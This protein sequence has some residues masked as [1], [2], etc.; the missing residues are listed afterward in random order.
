MHA[1]LDYQTAGLE[2]ILVDCWSLLETGAKKSKAPFHTP[3]L[4]TAQADGCSLRTVVLRRV[5]ASQRLLI[6]HTDRRSAK[7]AE[8]GKHNSLSWLFYDPKKKIQ[9]RARGL[10]TLHFDDDLADE[11]WSRTRRM[12]R[13]CYCVWEAPGTVQPSRSS[14]LPSEYEGGSPTWEQSEQGRE[15]FAVIRCQVDFLDWLYLDA[16]G[17]SRA[18]FHWCGEKF[19]ARWVTP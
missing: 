1:T 8:L 11:Q 6:C 4:G 16:R 3:V 9:I 2:D 15:N 14:G 12:S 5:V 13:R 10:A 17:H 7:V 19:E 18:Q